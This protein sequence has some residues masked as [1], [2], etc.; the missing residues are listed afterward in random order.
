MQNLQ[1]HILHQENHR[2]RRPNH[3]Q[4]EGDNLEAILTSVNLILQTF[5]LPVVL[6]ENTPKLVLKSKQ[7]QATGMTN[8]IV[9]RKAIRTKKLKQ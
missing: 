2:H 5:D 7:S 4:H 8:L 6:Q 9:F 3:N 1:H